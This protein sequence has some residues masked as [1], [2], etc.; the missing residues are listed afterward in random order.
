[1]DLFGDNDL[2]YDDDDIN[3]EADEGLEEGTTDTAGFQHP[4]AMDI[5]LG[6]EAIE[7]S[8]L[9]LFNSGRMPHGLIFAGQKGIGKATMAY[10]I[11]RFML[12]HGM[13][14]ASQGGLFGDAPTKPQSFTVPTD[15]PIF[16]RVAAGAHADVMTV[17]RQYDE[18]KNRYKSG[19]DV[20]EIRKVAPFLRMT[21]ADGGWRVVIIDD[22]DTMNRNAQNAILKILEEPPKNAI[23]ILIAHRLGTLVP[24]I[25]SRA[26][27]IQFSPLNAET[28]RDLLARQRSDYTPAQM[29]ILTRL[30]D[31]SVGK[32]LQY[33]NEKG[34]ETLDRILRS[35]QSYPNW[36]RADLHNLSEEMARSGREQDYQTF[37]ELLQWVFAQLAV[38]KARGHVIP[39]RVLETE[40]LQ[41]IMRN[42]S[43]EQLLGI[44]DNLHKHFERVEF[45]NLDKR[46]GVLGAFSLIA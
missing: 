9:E 10:R 41:A 18:V 24:T 6:H 28:L 7:K 27:V 23:L 22:A 19:V 38:A 44:C 33:I 37:D 26:Q 35:L 42:S 14:D 5:S 21:A 4:R 15:D 13:Q 45:A 39:A 36:N 25:R 12:K 31:G 29:D 43:L 11:G 40:A 34:L 1:M 30:A 20:D 8:L 46:Q 2:N 17:E 32:A 16:R 3:N